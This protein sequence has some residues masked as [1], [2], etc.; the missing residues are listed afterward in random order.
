ME[1]KVKL[2]VWGSSLGVIIPADAVKE[3]GLKEGDE[4]VV[5]I[6]KQTLADAFGML[7]GWK[8]DSQKVKDQ[9]RKEWSKW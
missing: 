9:L 1:A 6:R 7:K 5:E 3:A 2:K 8:V 4:I